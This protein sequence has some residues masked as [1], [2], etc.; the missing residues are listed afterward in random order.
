MKKLY[1]LAGCN[2]AGKTTVSYTI[3]PKILDC[4]EFVN[5]DEIA[6]GLSPFHPE[7]AAIQAGKLMLDKINRLISKGQNFALETT[8]ATK[9]YRNVVSKAKENGYHIVLLFFWLKTPDLAVKRVAT[10]VKEG[11]HN[12]PEEIIRRRY[13]NGLKNFFG[14]FE[15]IVDEWTFIDNSRKSYEIIAEKNSIGKLLINSNKWNKIVKIYKS[16]KHG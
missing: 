13:E 12:I 1:L 4:E 9:S 2:G 16:N 10:R 11:G 5:A 7:L 15:S 3:L 8:L 14:I 6:K